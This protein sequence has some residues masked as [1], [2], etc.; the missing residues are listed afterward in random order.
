MPHPKFRSSKVTRLVIA[1]SCR[2]LSATNAALNS[3]KILILHNFLIQSSIRLICSS[4]I[5]LSCNWYHYKLSEAY[6]LKVLRRR[7]LTIRTFTAFIKLTSNHGMVYF[8]MRGLSN[9]RLCLQEGT[10]SFSYRLVCLFIESA[11]GLS[12]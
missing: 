5:L 2:N 1:I 6:I 9:N 8:L 11:E 12:L 10:F 4:S 7:K 3:S